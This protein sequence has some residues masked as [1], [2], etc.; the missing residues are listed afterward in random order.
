MS[1][2]RT[3]TRTGSR[4]RARPGVLESGLFLRMAEHVV[5]AGAG[6]VEV[7]SRAGGSGR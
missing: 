1:L 4:L 3:P 2:L 7:R 5:V 6:G